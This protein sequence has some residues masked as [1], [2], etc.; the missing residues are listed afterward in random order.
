MMTRLNRAITLPVLLT[1]QMASFFQA[2]PCGVLNALEKA[3]FAKTK[4]YLRCQ[5]QHPQLG[6]APFRDVRLT[7]L[8]RKSSWDERD[9]ETTYQDKIDNQKLVVTEKNQN[10]LDIEGFNMS[11]RLRGNRA[12]RL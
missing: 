3:E 9:L 7:I 5:S 2:L 8:P 6:I 1:S 11:Q 12:G 10:V 4:V